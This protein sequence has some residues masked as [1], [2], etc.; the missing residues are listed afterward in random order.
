M[1][2]LPT[3]FSALKTLSRLCAKP[4]PSSSLLR[5]NLLPRIQ[6]QSQLSRFTASSFYS[7]ATSPSPLTSSPSSPSSP[8]THKPKPHAPNPNPK[9]EYEMTFTCTP[10]STRSTHRVSK[11]G[12]HKGSVLVTCPECKNRHIISDNLNIFG[13]KTLTIEDL[14]RE[15]GQ[16]VRKGTLSE[17]GNFEF[18][19][20]GTTTTRAK[21]TSES[22]ENA[23]REEPGKGAE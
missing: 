2:P 7:T 19:A 3:P 23:S 8:S 9:P 11:Q 16:L 12:Y 22:T 18:W 1:P 6:R 5:Q 4:T 13:D 21:P 14:M 10:C 17:D 20:D 15:Q